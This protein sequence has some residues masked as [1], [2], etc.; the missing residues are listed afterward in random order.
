MNN[1]ANVRGNFLPSRVLVSRPL[2]R[3]RAILALIPD[4]S[5]FVGGNTARLE[6][7]AKEAVPTLTAVLPGTMSE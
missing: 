5:G 2:T 3:T 4:P 6:A 7:F 1:A